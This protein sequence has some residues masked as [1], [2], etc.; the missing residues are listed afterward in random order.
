MQFEVSVLFLFFLDTYVLKSKDYERQTDKERECFLT[1]LDHS[2]DSSDSQGSGS[3][4]GLAKTGACN[5]VH[6]SQ[7]D[8]WGQ[9]LGPSSTTL[10]RTQAWKWIEIGQRSLDP[11]P[12]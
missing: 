3:A 5:C 2:P 11:E 4:L 7:M 1:L 12:V 6:I 8:D 10:E 9:A